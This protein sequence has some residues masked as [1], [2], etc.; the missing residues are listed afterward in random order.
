MSSH[1]TPIRGGG[2]GGMDPQVRQGGV[3]SSNDA[4]KQMNMK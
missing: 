2:G 3:N 4:I 1:F